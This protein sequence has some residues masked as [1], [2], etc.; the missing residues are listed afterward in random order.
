MIFDW[1]SNSKRIDASQRLSSGDRWER[2]HSYQQQECYI[3]YLQELG[4]TPEEMRRKWENVMGR[5]DP[6]F[7]LIGPYGRQEEFRALLAQSISLPREFTQAK[8]TPIAITR[9]EIDRINGLQCPRWFRKYVFLILGYYKFEKAYSPTAFFPAEVSGWAYEQARKGESVA[10][11]RLHRSSVWPWNRRCGSPIGVAS[12]SG[13]V[14]L[15]IRW[16]S[17]K[18]AEEAFSFIDPN[19]LIGHFGLISPWTAKCERCGRE[20]RMADKQKVRLCPKCYNDR[21]R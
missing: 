14:A 16:A 13:K 9:E 8:S 11:Q 15:G 3:R 1:V 19:E 21:F 4:A 10:Q 20:F 17:E 12:V 2:K 18:P 6:E 5:T 7:R